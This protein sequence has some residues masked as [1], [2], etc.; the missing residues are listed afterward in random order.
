MPVGVTRG[1]S[2]A[3]SPAV[4]VLRGDCRK[5]LPAM[6]E[7]LVDSVVTDPPY[8]FASIVKRFGPNGAAP[9]KSNGATGVYERSS[10]GFMGKTWDGGSVAFDPATWVAVLR[11]LKPGGHML[12]FGAPKTAHR[13][14]C[15]IEDAGFE[16]RDAVMWLFGSGFPKSHNAGKGRGTALKPAYELI[17]L[18]RKPLVGTIA[19]N[20]L[21]W[22]TGAINIDG[23]RVESAETITTHSRGVSEQFAK[24]PGERTVAESGRSVPQNRAEF[25]GNPRLGRWPANVIHDGS[26]EVRAAFP[27]APGALAA[28][29]AHQTGHRTVH[30]Y[31]T[32]NGERPERIP[33]GDTGSAARF[34]YCAK[35]TKA[36]RA[37]S[38]HPTVKPIALMRY[39]CRLVTPPGGVILDPFAGTGSTGQAALKE[40]FSAILCERE[41]EY[42]A[43]I[44]RRL[45]KFNEASP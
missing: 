16:I 39:L 9:V 43:D 5:L 26:E 30:A 20:V 17:T 14:T 4:Q 23:C 40:G 35:A 24:R 21:A 10:R 3:V 6:P 2:R 13:L 37:G 31:G 27:D 15:A 29:G 1:K 12:A 33:R 18:A 36:E 8:H 32:F 45:T 19:A 34:F 11:V 41:A 42:V 25:I 22:G 28:V 44:K 38:K 7:N